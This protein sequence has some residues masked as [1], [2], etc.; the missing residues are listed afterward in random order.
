G[1]LTLLL[2]FAV[3]LS[4]AQQKTITGTVTDETGM[5]LPGVNIV[6]V[7]TSTG[8][9]SDFDGNYSINASVGQAIS[10]SYLGYETAEV[11]VTASTTTI[12]IQMSED[13]ATLEEVIVTAYGRKRTK[14]EYTGSVVTVGSEDLMKIPNVSVE[15]ALQGRVA[16]LA[17]N[18]TSGTPGSSQQIR[19]RGQQS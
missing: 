4:F 15:Q 3:Q 17:V 10:F 14:N 1:I 7:G 9:Q 18:T 2:A 16:G 11:P 13:A 19:I 5:P 6:I 8:T 12:S